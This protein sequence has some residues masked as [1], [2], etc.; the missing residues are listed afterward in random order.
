PRVGGHDCSGPDVRAELCNIQEC[1]TS[2]QDYKAEQCALTDSDPMDGQ[3]FHWVPVDMTGEQSCELHCKIDGQRTV[4]LR[5]LDNKNWYHDGTM[6]ATVSASFGRCIS[7]KCVELG[8][9]GKSGSQ[10]SFDKCG[11]CGGQ[12][13]TCRKMTGTYNQGQKQQ[14]VTFVTIPKGATSAKIINKNKFTQMSVK[15][16]GKRI[17]NENGGMTDRAGTYVGGGVVAQYLTGFGVDETITISGPLPLPVQAQVWRQFGDR[18][19]YQGVAPEITYEYHVPSA[20][21]NSVY[22]QIIKCTQRSSGSQVDDHFCDIWQKPK[23]TGSPCN[24]Q[25]CPPRWRTGHYGQC[26][27]SCGGGQQTRPV[28]C[29]RERN[30][31]EEVVGSNSCPSNRRPLSTRQ[32]NVNVLCPAVWITGAWSACSLTCGKG[33][34]SRTVSCASDDA[35]K[36]PVADSQCQEA[37]PA[38]HQQCIMAVC[39]PG[40]TGDACKDTTQDCSNYGDTMC[41]DY[42]DYAKSSC[43]KHCAI[44][45]VDGTVAGAGGTAGAVCEDKNADC[46]QYGT[47]V[48]TGEYATWAKDNCAKMCGHCS[49]ACKDKNAQCEGYGQSVCT[50]EYAAWARDNC[51]KFCGLCG[52]GSSTGNCQDTA[53]NCR[54]YGASVCTEYADWAAENCQQLCNKCGA[55]RRNVEGSIALIGRPLD[56]ECNQIIVAP[57]GATIHL[58]F[59]ALRISCEDGDWLEVKEDGQKAKGEKARRDLCDQAEPVQWTTSGN[60]ATILLT[61]SVPGD[62]YNLTY[63]VQDGPK[64][65]MPGCSQQLTDPSGKFSSPNFP[66]KYPASSLCFT[67]IIAPPGFSVQ[68]TFSMFHMEGEQGNCAEDS[69]TLHDQEF[70]SKDV[71]CGIQHELAWQS[72]GNRVKVVFASDEKESGPGFYASYKFIAP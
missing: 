30:G 51:A 58:S 63:Q 65:K 14:Y 60:V 64:D 53:T 27:K 38:T 46:P 57:E 71:F 4:L 33:V 68:I 7:G 52:G 12:G 44:C 18:D 55:R 56:I 70:G 49:S 26:S 40:V 25:A 1:G 45:T 22:N 50:G 43:M 21:T 39:S 20:N 32:C 37:K 3:Q 48:C 29:V 13:N 54:E 36:S 67:S 9:D 15:I 23:Q 69:L 41:Q 34:K 8:C 35:S 17:F 42:P 62:G 66:D 16:G 10:Y 6:C 61:I 72:Q 28:E 2:Q 24:N 5:R 59:T 19:G 47:S 11:V 31:V